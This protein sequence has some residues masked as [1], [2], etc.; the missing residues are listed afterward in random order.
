MKGWKHWLDAAFA[1]FDEQ[2]GDPREA[3]HTS[4]GGVWGVVFLALAGVAGV[5]LAG[6]GA[7]APF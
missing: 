3:S 4:E 6:P 7:A 5:A 1:R 2:A